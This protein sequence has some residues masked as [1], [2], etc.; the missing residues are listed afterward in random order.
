MVKWK[1]FVTFL[2]ASSFLTACAAQEMTAATA[3]APT[4]ESAAPA[5]TLLPE[6][7]PVVDHCLECHT[8]K[9][10]LTALAKEEETGHNSE[11]EGVG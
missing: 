3:T 4:H 9:D 10:K 11:S 8:D 6:P 7:A 1:Y 5:A 2:L